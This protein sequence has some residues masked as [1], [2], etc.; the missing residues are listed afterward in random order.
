[1]EN[2]DTGPGPTNRQTYF[3]HNSREPHVSQSLG[4]PDWRL[5]ILPSS[6]FQTGPSLN[7][8]N[9]FITSISFFSLLLVSFIQNK[10]QQ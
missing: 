1:M 6:V 10:L 3:I 2:D 9:G 7:K 5:G 8:L 4:S